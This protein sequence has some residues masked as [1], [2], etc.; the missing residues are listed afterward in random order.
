[1]AEV[2]MRAIMGT[3]RLPEREAFPLVLRARLDLE[4]LLTGRIQYALDDLAAALNT[5]LVYAERRLPSAKAVVRE[6]QETLLK[7]DRRW[8]SGGQQAPLGA[9]EA[10]ALV[11]VMEMYEDMLAT[12]PRTV[13][14]DVMAEVLQRLERGRVLA[15]AAE[16]AQSA[17]PQ[18]RPVAAATTAALAVA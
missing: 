16:R 14:F 17:V 3:S 1:M 2:R 18:R 15:V 5:C 7:A 6:A 10:S 11:A 9:Q 4:T 12:L 13:L 8:R